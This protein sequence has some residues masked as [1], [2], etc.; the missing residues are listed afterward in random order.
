MKYVLGYIKLG[1]LWTLIINDSGKK[2]TPSVLIS[3]CKSS[4]LYS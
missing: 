2:F 3:E 1:V 4:L